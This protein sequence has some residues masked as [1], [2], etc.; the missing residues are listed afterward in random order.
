M[1]TDAFT[2]FWTDAMGRMASAG[3]MPTAA[4]PPPNLM[5][6]M[7][8]AFFEGMTKHAEEYLRSEQFLTGMKQTMDHALAARQQI[9]DFLTKNLQA[10]QMPSASD[11]GEV[12]RVVRNMEDRL[13]RQ[14]DGMSKRIERLE[15][16]KAKGER[17]NGEMEK[18]G[19][20]KTLKR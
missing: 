20:A 12:V 11:V 3:V 10:F 6:Q 5:E 1:S 9:N 19:K 13:E 8:D 2:R 18:G 15:G 17:R 16:K 7:R 4:A 14:L